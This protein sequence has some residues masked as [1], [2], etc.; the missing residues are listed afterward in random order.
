VSEKTSVECGGTQ[1]A[2]QRWKA[3]LKRLARP[4]LK[5]YSLGL[6]MLRAHACLATLVCTG[7]VSAVPAASNAGFDRLP[8][9]VLDITPPTVRVT[10]A[11]G[12]MQL[13]PRPCRTLAPAAVRR[14]IVDITVQE[15]GFFGFLVRDE[16]AAADMIA[17]Q[18]AAGG[19]DGIW[20][21]SFRRSLFARL[22]PDEAARV[23]TSVA[24][25]WAVTPEAG[26]MVARQNKSWREPDPP[27][28]ADPWSAAFVS[29][30]MCEAGLGEPGRFQRAI[31]HHVYIDQAI[32]ARVGSAPQAA[33]VAYDAGEAAIA[34]GDL[35][36]ASRRPVY[37]SLAERRRQTGVGART[38]CDIVVRIDEATGRISVVGGNVGRAVSLKLLRGARGRAGHLEATSL[39]EGRPVF[40]HLKLRATA[41]EAD[42]LDNSPTIRRSVC[43]AGDEAQRRIAAIVPAAVRVC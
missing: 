35:L 2:Q 24:G 29:W 25:Y 5:P 4:R 26:A 1:E 17:T 22:D 23:A 11:P 28:R 18:E 37:R 13:H 33:F 15:W 12:E 32:R 8:Q 10:G 40:A 20:D 43:A 7:V 16:V 42:A 41:I 3:E 31:A 38:H 21:E 39:D 34:P 6:R 19:V 27:G 14:R 9:H 36:C 30:V